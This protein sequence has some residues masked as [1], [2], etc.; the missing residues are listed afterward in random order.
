M[1]RVAVCRPSS[2]TPTSTM[3]VR[4][5]VTILATTTDL[6]IILSASSLMPWHRRT[7]NA[8]YCNILQVFSKCNVYTYRKNYGKLRRTEDGSVHCP[9]S[10]TTVNTWPRCTWPIL[11]VSNFAHIIISL[12]CTCSTLL[13]FQGARYRLNTQKVLSI[14]RRRRFR[15]DTEVR[16]VGAHPPFWLLEPARVKPN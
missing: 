2:Q 4:L 11:P 9:S 1:P 14:W 7:F 3:Q 13:P 12:F 16:C 5:V 6:K 10:I 15:I 8:W